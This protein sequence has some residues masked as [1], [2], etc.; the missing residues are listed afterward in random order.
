LAGHPARLIAAFAAG[1]GP[2]ELK[3]AQEA[4]EAKGV[5]GVPSFLF[6]DGDLGT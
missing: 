3:A 5:F 1:E 2:R 6:P 4:A